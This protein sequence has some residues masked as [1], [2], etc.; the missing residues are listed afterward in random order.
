MFN[1]SLKR[2]R[3]AASLAA[4][5]VT[6]SVLGLCALAHAEDPDGGGRS[7]ATPIK[8]LI[9]V[10]GENWSF[11]QVFGTYMPQPGQTVSNLL[12]K[13]IVKPDG[14]RDTNF[15]EAAQFTTSGHGTYFISAANKVPYAIL[16]PPDLNGAPN[17]QSVNQPPFPSVAEAAAVEPALE[18]GDLGLLTTGATNAAGT[19]GVDTRVPNAS[20]LLNGPFQLTSKTLPYDSYTG[21][22]T[23]RFYQMWQ[24][25][26]CSMQNATRKNPTGCLNDFYPFVITTFA[27][28]DKGVGNSMGFLN[29]NANDAP[30]LKQLAD[31]F[32]LSDNYH[33]PVMGGTG[34]QHVMLGTGDDVFW[35]DGHG[36]P[37]PP[38][39]ALIANPNPQP[40]SNNLYTVDGNWSNCSDPF[41]P[42]V[43]PI[44]SYLETLPYEAESNCTPGHYYML[45]N[46][47]PGYLTNGQP[48]PSP[49][50][51][52]PSS[53]RTIGDALLEKNIS[54]R[55]YG[56]AFN[57]NLA[58]AP[59]G[60]AYCDICN[61]FQYATSIMTDDLVRTTHLK[62]V[63]DLFADLQ[64]GALPAVSI[65]KPDGL[66]DGHPAS[67]KL[68][69]FEAFVKDILDRLQGDPAQLAET[70][71]IITFDE[72]G[73]FYDSGYIQPLDFF[74][75]GPR[76][77]AIVV[78]PFSKGGR[79]VHTYY[80]HVSILKF[81]E[82]NW[83]LDPLT[84]RSR[85]NLPN[86]VAREDN[87]YVPINS[88]AIGDLFDLFRF[89]DDHGREHGQ[90]G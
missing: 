81:I 27:K 80:D 45:N 66:V 41:Q 17:K 18:T 28:T 6:A 42:G 12:S 5:V 76:I 51:V 31:E 14:T 75:D 15:A 84:E 71:L 46:T 38:P 57:A 60:I 24:Q 37:I 22:T 32:T 49:T 69:L 29:V 89:D 9:V 44:V 79:V 11:D 40:G 62:D 47:S 53:V 8:H 23:H 20:A 86:P 78:S 16:P 56:G 58:G 2:S 36:N 73:G 19:Q 83:H 43:G 54:W 21:D 68:D 64:A 72:G 67:S 34:V 39:A 33:Q 52:P 63:T 90:G 7:T 10:T 30:F 55:Y 35:S 74:G 88:P 4:S 77:P 1:N 65:V 82:R 13:R 70:A 85:D 48:N 61:P 59:V 87:P 25:S 3:F 26:D 50:V